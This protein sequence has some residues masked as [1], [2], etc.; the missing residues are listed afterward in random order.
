MLLRSSLVAMEVQEAPNDSRPPTPDVIDTGTS[1]MEV[2]DQAEA[3]E[4]IEALQDSKGIDGITIQE[5][6]FITFSPTKDQGRHT[7]SA[8]SCCHQPASETAAAT[9]MPEVEVDP[10]RRSHQD[11]DGRG[12]HHHRESSRRSR[13]DERTPSSNRR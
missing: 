12:R 7:D 4:P 8:H 11:D 5:K 6:D 13:R 1:D 9:T 3:N 10:P 2:G